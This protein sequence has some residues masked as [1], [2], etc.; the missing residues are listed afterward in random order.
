MDQWE[1]KVFILPVTNPS[2][3]VHLNE[4][5]ADGWELAS[6]SSAGRAVMKRLRTAPESV[7][8]DA[9]GMPQAP[10]WYQDPFGQ[11]RL[12]WWDGQRWTEHTND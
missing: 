7:E 2:A 8:P 9:Q 1:Y 4:L 10:N 6:L 12:R 11:S 5:G 3:E